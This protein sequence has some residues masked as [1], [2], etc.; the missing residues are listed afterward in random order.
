MHR[1]T[2]IIAIST[3]GVTPFRPDG[4]EVGSGDLFDTMNKEAAGDDLGLTLQT[5]FV[6]KALVGLLFGSDLSHLCY[7]AMLCGP[8][9]R[10]FSKLK[11]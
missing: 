11:F 3:Y 9:K 5:S 2:I 10:N 8:Q 4:L 6:S 7:H 1:N